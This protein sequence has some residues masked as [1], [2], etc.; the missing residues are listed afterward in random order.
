MAL[1]SERRR[2][3]AISLARPRPIATLTACCG[4][5]SPIRAS[6]ARMTAAQGGV[7]I[8][9][10]RHIPQVRS[11]TIGDRGRFPAGEPDRRSAIAA[12]SRRAK[13]GKASS[14]EQRRADRTRRC[15][16]RWPSN[17]ARAS[18]N[19]RSSPGSARAGSSPSSAGWPSA[20]SPSRLGAARPIMGVDRSGPRRRRWPGVY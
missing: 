16:P 14:L 11:S 15:S 19:W 17:R 13:G 12:T 2:R 4:C 10:R 8:A 20:A 6:A 18:C 3:A 9:P 1:S 5:A 7:D